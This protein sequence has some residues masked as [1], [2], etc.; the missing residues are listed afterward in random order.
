MYPQNVM[1]E[2]S[3]TKTNYGKLGLQMKKVLNTEQTILTYV[4]EIINFFAFQN[5]ILQ[6]SSHEIDICFCRLSQKV[7]E[8]CFGIAHT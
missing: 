7:T 3:L 4:A 6:V 5:L 2:C 1:C 8:V